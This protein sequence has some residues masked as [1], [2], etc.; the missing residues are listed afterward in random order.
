[1][2]TLDISKFR[3]HNKLQNLGRPNTALLI[4]MHIIQYSKNTKKNLGSNYNKSIN[5]VNKQILLT[6]QTNL[7]G[8]TELNQLKLN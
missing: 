4:N 1:M 3:K 6:D 2:Q 8:L 7:E 5:Q